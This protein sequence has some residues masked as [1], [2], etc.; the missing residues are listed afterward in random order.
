MNYNPRD[1]SIGSLIEGSIL[2]NGPYFYISLSIYKIPPYIHI[3]LVNLIFVDGGFFD[4]LILH[5]FFIL[6]L[7]LT[8]KETIITLYKINPEVDEGF[9]GRSLL[10]S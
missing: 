5:K 6:F 2:S 10:T 7:I 3:V 9:D 4:I 1:V 8:Q